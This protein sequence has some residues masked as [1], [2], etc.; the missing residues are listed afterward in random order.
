MNTTTTYLHSFKD[1]ST[2][3]AKWLVKDLQDSYTSAMIN[4]LLGDTIRNYYWP[5]GHKNH[6]ADHE[7]LPGPFPDGCLI[8][9]ELMPRKDAGA[10]APAADMI[11]LGDD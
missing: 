10:G 5:V 6:R 1:T 8:P 4:K 3:P 9:L 2:K 7:K 11:K